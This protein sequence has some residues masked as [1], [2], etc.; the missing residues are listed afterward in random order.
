MDRPLGLA[1]FDGNGHGDV[2]LVA[3]GGVV[4]FL[5]GY[6]GSA[7]VFFG[8]DA[9]AH[10]ADRTPMRIAGAFGSI[11]C[12]GFYALAFIRGKGGPVLNAAPLP[13]A[14]ATLAP[15]AFRWLV[16][17]ANWA[18]LRERFGF[19][20]LR[21]DLFVDAVTLLVPG[22]AFFV[23]VLAVW[24]SLLGDGE[25]EAWQREHLDGEFYRE[26]VEH[27]GNR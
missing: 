23:A 18:G 8:L 16:F 27:A 12:W 11:A 7:V 4:A 3:L 15:V 22:V 14:T 17:G 9:L 19:F 1:P 26:F 13:A 6:A 20:L 2:A 24:A 25:I 5:T 10:G 21:L